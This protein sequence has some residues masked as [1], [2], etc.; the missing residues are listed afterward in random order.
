MLF[1]D[2]LAGLGQADDS[3]LSELCRCLSME[4]LG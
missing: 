4:T 2:L 1:I 3:R